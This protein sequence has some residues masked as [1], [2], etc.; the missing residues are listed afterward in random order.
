MATFN[1]TN[2]ENGRGV[3]R[4][5]AKENLYI[6]EDKYQ[7]GEVSKKKIKDMADNWDWLLAGTL[8]VVEHGGRYAVI[9]G[10]H[11]LRAAM[12]LNGKIR[13]LPCMVYKVNSIVDEA[14]GFLGLQ[15]L[16]TNVK[17]YE[18]HNAALVAKDPMAVKVD[19]I[20]RDAGY[21]I[22]KNGTGN[23]VF[24]A[25]SALYVIVKVDADVAAEAISV[26]SDIAGGA[27]IFK[28]VLMGVFEVQYQ[29]RRQ[30][31]RSALTDSNI[32]KLKKTGMNGLLA[33]INNVKAL[34]ASGT[35]DNSRSISAKGIL[36]ILNKGRR[37][38]GKINITL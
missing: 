26:C 10:G 27:R 9:D 23:Y 33:S 7:R 29:S 15:K 4:M 30:H 37:G 32:E 18:N 38:P 5:I 19:Q 8:T 36:N 13:E 21:E 35:G 1:Y 28:Q 2:S 3:Y 34:A 14:K 17:S 25:V 20:V 22:R 6:P 12:R 31:N 11:R 24:D 16:R